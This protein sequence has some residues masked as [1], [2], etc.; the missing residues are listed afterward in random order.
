MTQRIS[1]PPGYTYEAYLKAHGASLPKGFFPYEWMDDI[2]KLNHSTLPSQDA[3]FS[4]LTGKSISDEDYSALKEK[5]S[6]LGMTRVRDLLVWYNNL[7]VEPF[8]EALQ[9]Q[10]AIYASR[11]IDMGKQ[12]ISLPGLAVLWMESVIGPRPTNRQ[13][14]RDTD[15]EVDGYVSIYQSIV[16]SLCVQVID[17][18]NRELHQL[19]RDN[20]VGGPSIVFHRYHSK[21]ETTLRPAEMIADPKTCQIIQGYDANALYLYLHYARHA[22]WSSHQKTSGKR[23]PSVTC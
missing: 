6:Q 16:N 15:N 21:G 8:L 19:F 1:F 23:I 7:D 14:F 11:G 9:K 20:L 2:N 3:F 4:R 22:R 17:E 18:D 5:W 12:A 10:Y 13:L